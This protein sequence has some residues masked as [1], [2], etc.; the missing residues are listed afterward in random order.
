[1]SS[2]TITALKVKEYKGD[3]DPYEYMSHFERKMHTMLVSVAKLEAIK[4][5]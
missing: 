2:S 3:S 4:C 5:R 1:M